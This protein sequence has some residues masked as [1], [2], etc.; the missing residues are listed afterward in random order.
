MLL[1]LNS[2]AIFFSYSRRKT[3]EILQAKDLGTAFTLTGSELDVQGATCRNYMRQTWPTTGEA[4]VELVTGALRVQQGC[5]FMP[6]GAAV[7]IAEIGEQ[8]AWLGAAVGTFPREHNKIAYC[9]PVIVEAPDLDNIA[10]PR[11]ILQPS[12]ESINPQI[13]FQ[14]EETSATAQHGGCVVVKGYPI[15]QGNMRRESSQ[16]TIGTDA[17]NRSIERLCMRE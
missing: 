13:M 10:S 15:S 9:T 3:P 8:L 5:A 11:S 7:S 6:Y 4:I 1:P 14:M 12:L 2:N 16:R 17:W